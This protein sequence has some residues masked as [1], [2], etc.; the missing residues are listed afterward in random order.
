MFSNRSGSQRGSIQLVTGP[1]FSGKT[2][3]LLHRLRR[4]GFAKRRVMLV[5]YCRDTRYSADAVA[6]HDRFTACGASCKTFSVSCLADLPPGVTDGFDVVGVDEGQFFPDL[7][8][9]ADRT[10]SAGKLVIVCGLDGD[11]LRQPFG[12]LCDLVSRAESLTKLTAV[13]QGTGCRRNASFSTRIS[14]ETGVEVIGGADKYIPTCRLCYNRLAR[15]AERRLLEQ[16][17]ARERAVSSTESPTCP[18]ATATDSDDCSSDDGRAVS[19]PCTE[20]SSCSSSSSAASS[21]S[22]SAVKDSPGTSPDRRT[23][24]STSPVSVM[25]SLAE[26]GGRLELVIGP[27]FSG[28]TTQMLHRIR[29][30]GFANRRVLLVKYCKDQRYSVSA[31]ATHDNVTGGGCDTLSVA[32]LAQVGEAYQK[33]D[34]IGVDEGQFYPDLGACVDQWASEGKTVIVA[35]LDGDFLRHPFGD[36]CALVPRAE[37]VTKITAVCM[38]CGCNAAF[39][40]RISAEQDVEVIGGADKYLP[41]CRECYNDFPAAAGDGWNNGSALTPPKAAAKLFKTTSVGPVEGPVRQQLFRE[42]GV[43]R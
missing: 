12:A 8:E 4:L 39:S 14:A 9:F 16:Q 13:C 5:R 23:P 21:L 37:S 29:R 2:T 34:V 40:K 7:L 31:V 24:P 43:T 3:E 25:E 28:K 18:A 27:M 32:A 19:P 22:A 15:R 30:H 42:G 1:M 41:T 35:A 38:G 11:F 33:Y 17:Q 36:V 10:A 26:T 20:S 6:T